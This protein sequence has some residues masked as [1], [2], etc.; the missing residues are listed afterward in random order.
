MRIFFLWL[1]KNFSWVF[2][3]FGLTVILIPVVLYFHKFGFGLWDSHE[4]W[5]MMGD[6][7]AGT[8]GP[9]ITAFSL[10]FL[11]LQVKEQTSQRKAGEVSRRCHESVVDIK[12]Y[13]EKTKEKLPGRVDANLADSAREIFRIEEGL[14]NEDLDE[15]IRVFVRDNISLFNSWCMVDQELRFLKREDFAQYQRMHRYILSHIDAKDLIGLEKI[16]V[17]SIGGE[18]NSVIYP[19]FSG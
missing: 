17:N 13:I 15:V 14:S 9:I 2:V 16:R 8:L 11:G 19:E 3:I 5:A 1:K 10:I 6:F 4:D 7:F 12:M 18:K